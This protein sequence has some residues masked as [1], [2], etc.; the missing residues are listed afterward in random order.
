MAGFGLGSPIGLKEI[1]PDQ[2]EKWDFGN[3]FLLFGIPKMII[4]DSD[5]ILWNLQEDFKRYCTNPST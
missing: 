2:A 1:I 4:V 3:F 5:G